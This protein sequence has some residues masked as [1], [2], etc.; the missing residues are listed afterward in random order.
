MHKDIGPSLKSVKT[1]H[2]VKRDLVKLFKT[3]KQNAGG[4]YQNW[5]RCW[6][7]YL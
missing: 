6:N 1:L 4:D 7:N 3:T 2:H 5:L